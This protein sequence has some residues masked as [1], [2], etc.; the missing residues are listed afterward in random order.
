MLIRST[1]EI[2]NKSTRADGAILRDHNVSLILHLAW[3]AGEI[4]RIDLARESGLAPST[5][6][7][8][9]GNLIS[10]GVLHEARVAASASGRPPIVLQCDDS[11]YKL[12][13]IDL[14]ATHVSVALTNL[15][16][17]VLSWQTRT[18]DVQGDPEGALRLAVELTHAAIAEAGTSLSAVVGAGL[19][20][21]S[22]VDLADP[23]H[24]AERILPAWANVRPGAWLSRALGLSVAVEND[25]NLAALAEAW[26]G[27]GRG[28]GT[29]AYIKV[30]TGIGAGLI[31]NGTLLRGANGFA[32]EIGHTAIDSSGPPCACGLRGCLQSMV[33]SATVLERTRALVRSGRVSSVMHQSPMTLTGV[34]MAAAEGDPVAIE[35]VE[36]CGHHLGLAIANLFNLLNP[37]LVLLGGGLTAAGEQLL[38]PLRE[39]ISARTLWAS[40][41]QAEVRISALGPQAT[42]LGA[43]TLVLQAALADP[44]MFSRNQSKPPA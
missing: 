12:L 26:L 20:V 35:V 44:R 1:K 28:V 33:G 13:G 4:S 38:R 29:L 24:L 32:G 9:V 37:S 36:A 16:G 41:T 34:A 7:K 5:V 31:V 8:I 18:H 15:R 10:T 23:D 11:V 2:T 14:G 21:P 40:L 27:A 43:A 6:S 42:A 3:Q 19:G 30:G 39:A 25:A 17:R 22:P